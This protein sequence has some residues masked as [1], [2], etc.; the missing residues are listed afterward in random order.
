MTAPLEFS[1]RAHQTDEPPISYFIQQGVENPNLISLAAGLVDPESLPV[2]EVRAVT[3]EILADPRSAQAA[4]QYGTTQ[5]Y[6]PL[7]DKI[8]RHLLALD[9]LK[10]SE[11][12]NSADDIVLST[13]SQQLLYLLGEVLLNPGDIVIT[14]APS[15]FVYH[16]ILGSL[17]IRTLTVPMDDNGMNTDA[18]E[19]LLTRLEASGELPRVKLVYTVDYF[20]NP[21]GLTLSLP[22]RRH[23][24]DL[25]QRFSKT[26]RIL[27]LEDAAYRELRFDGDDVPSIKSIDRTNEYVILAMT[28]SK[29]LSP[30]LKTGYGVLPRDLVGPLLRF[31]GNHDFG[32]SNLDQH[33][34]DRVMANG[35]YQRHVEELR[36]VYRAKRD[37]LLAA[38]AEEF[39][40]ANS[41]LRWTRPVGGLYVWLICPPA[42]ET[43]PGSP[44]MEAALREGVLYVPGSF[45]YVKNG[46]VPNH[47]ARLCYGVASHEQIREAVRRLGKAAREVMPMEKITMRGLAG[48]KA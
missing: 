34:L 19:E 12:S 27:I 20:Q 30:G 24:L 6:G 43:G 47:E 22:R 32:S 9:G 46:V 31:K 17:G 45:C 35:S 1:T 33:I 4:L 42:L 7:R 25:V 16:G 38:L 18:L 48:C 36:G 29:P 3:N 10:P 13:G 14:E 11:V 21:T 39:P 5:G 23:L 2:E 26:Q 28:F 8:H 41:P 40:P 15:Y 37:T 44:F